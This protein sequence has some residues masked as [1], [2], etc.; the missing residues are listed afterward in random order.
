MEMVRFILSLAMVTGMPVAALAQGSQS[1]QT[2]GW[3]DIN[4][5]SLRSVQ[6]EQTYTYSQTVFRETATAATAYPKLP[7]A[8]GVGIDGG[9][10]F[11]RQL[12]V[13]VHFGG[14]NYDSTV[15]L[16]IR[17]PHPNLFNQFGT[18]ADVTATPLRREDRAVDISLMFTPPTS[19]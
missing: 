13:G 7:S 5:V 17:M 12:G 16:A 4:F 15:G 11:S 19:Q 9:V 10:Q 2:R 18:D 8:N 14:V 3:L 1:I 6:D